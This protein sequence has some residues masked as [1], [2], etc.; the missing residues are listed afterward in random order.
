MKTIEQISIKTIEGSINSPKGFS[1]TGE[2]IGIKKYKKD[3]A[4]IYSEVPA[5]ASAV[6]T[7]N[8]VKA[9]PILWCQKIIESKK[10]T[11]T[12]IFITMCSFAIKFFRREVFL[13]NSKQ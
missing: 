11:A 2:H 6:F 9:P 1:S 10:L 8:I 4:L 12:A 5:L 13:Q 3:L 7:Q